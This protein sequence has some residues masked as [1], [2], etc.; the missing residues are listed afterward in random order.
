MDYNADGQM[1]IIAGSFG[2]QFQLMKGTEKGFEKAVYLEDETG[3][4]VTLTSFWNFEKKEYDKLSPEPFAKEDQTDATKNTR[5]ESYTLIDWD[6]DQD[7]DLLIGGSWGGLYVRI[8]KGTAEAPAYGPNNLIARDTQGQPL[9]APSGHISPLVI[10][11]DGDGHNDIVT[12]TSNGAVCWFKNQGGK[13]KA[14]FAPAEVILDSIKGKTS[15]VEVI[16]LNRDGKLDLVI[17]NGS[18]KIHI[19]YQ[20]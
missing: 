17:G 3:K 16:D 12:G 13:T 7:M 19:Y 2:G 20:K 8:N 5:G 4:H 1:D 9:K 6:G 18:G 14:A 15:T 11:F 10:D